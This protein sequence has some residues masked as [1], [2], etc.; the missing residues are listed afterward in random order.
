[1]KS[2]KTTCTVR[3]TKQEC[4]RQTECT[5][6]KPETA[7]DDGPDADT[8]TPPIP[9]ESA[10]RKRSADASC[11]PQ[12][13]PLQSG[14]SIRAAVAS[15]PRSLVH[16]LLVRSCRASNFDAFVFHSRSQN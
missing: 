4:R 9:P 15:P 5:C 6:T 11:K 1:M 10:A 16:P 14:Q 3:P 2:C 7:E 12:A 8:S 13:R